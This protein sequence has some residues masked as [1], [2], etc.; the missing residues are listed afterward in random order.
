MQCMSNS[1]LMHDLTLAHLR[2]LDEIVRR[3]SFSRAAEALALSQPAVSLHI[4]HLERVLGTPLLERVGKRAF[5]TEA[6]RLLLAH[7]ERARAELDAAVQALARR[8]GVVAGR[9][10]LGTGATASIHHLPPLFRRLRARHPGLEL[11][12]VTGNTPDIVARLLSNELDLAVVTDPAASRRLR[13]APLLSDPLVAIA[14]ATAEWRRR[15]PITPAELARHPLI[16]YERGGAIRGVIDGWFRRAG[17]V[18]R[19][20]MELGSAEAIKKLV[21]AGLGL[22]VSPAVAVRAEVRARALRAI[23]LDPA[24]ARRLGVVW[25]RDK[26]DTPALAVVRQAL[27][28]LAG[29]ARGTDSAAPG[30]RSRR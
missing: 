21:E 9:V 1:W 28:E 2:T 16:L 6:G 10:R 22:S 20:A 14:P 3:G 7:A 15:R 13:V 30:R 11:Q 18:P 17:V 25:R 12:V 29:G 26:P 24:L 4:R 8:R 23:P 27:A 19:V 5:P